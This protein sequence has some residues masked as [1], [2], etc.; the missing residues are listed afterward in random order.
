MLYYIY[1]SSILVFI[2]KN[3]NLDDA[4]GIEPHCSVPLTRAVSMTSTMMPAPL[5][6]QGED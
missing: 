4:Q 1:V 5:S 2:S 3:F 6:V